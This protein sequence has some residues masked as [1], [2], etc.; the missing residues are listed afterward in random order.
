VIRGF[1][2]AMAASSEVMHLM[3]VHPLHQ[4]NSLVA[5]RGWGVLALRG[6]F[7]KGLRPV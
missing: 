1:A 5:F 4:V 7:A 3:L 2:V 6:F